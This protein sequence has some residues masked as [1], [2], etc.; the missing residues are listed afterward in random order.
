MVTQSNVLRD[1]E[2]IAEDALYELRDMR[3]GSIMRTTPRIAEILLEY[4]WRTRTEAEYANWF[5]CVRQAA[6]IVARSGQLP[7]GARLSSL[8]ERLWVR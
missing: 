8:A 6:I 2:S 1:A 7:G 3:L 4:R 5:E